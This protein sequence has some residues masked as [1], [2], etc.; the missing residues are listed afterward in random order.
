MII[1]ENNSINS[2]RNQTYLRV[3]SK[4]RA[5]NSSSDQKSRKR[6]SM[7]SMIGR[8]SWSTRSSSRR[9]KSRRRSAH[10]RSIL[11]KRRLV[12]KSSRIGK[13]EKNLTIAKLWQHRHLRSP[14]TISSRRMYMDRMRTRAMQPQSL[15]LNLISGRPS[16]SKQ[17][18]EVTINMTTQTR[19]NN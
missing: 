8:R 9:S 10:F 5:G 16:L 2:R 13:S 4:V 18:L 19:D 14:T 3:Q 12:A 11:I 1:Y 6:N 17:M 7:H 15:Q